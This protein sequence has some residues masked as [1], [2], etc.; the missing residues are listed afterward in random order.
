MTEAWLI[1]GGRDQSLLDIIL[2]KS[3]TSSIK[4]ADITIIE[5]MVKLLFNMLE[6][7]VSAIRKQTDFVH[8]VSLR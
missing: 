7:L 4:Y 5:I 3:G 8:W 6:V 2:L 1:R